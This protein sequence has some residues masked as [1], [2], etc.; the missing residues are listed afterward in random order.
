MISKTDMRN[1]TLNLK[2]ESEKGKNNAVDLRTN[3]S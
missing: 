3:N 2:F 1:E